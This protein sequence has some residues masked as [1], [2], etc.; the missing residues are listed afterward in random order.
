MLRTPIFMPSP[1]QPASTWRSMALAALSLLYVVISTT[2][3]FCRRLL[4][5]VPI[6]LFWTLTA[7]SALCLDKTLAL[8][9][10]ATTVDAATLPVV[11]MHLMAAGVGVALPFIALGM[12]GNRHCL[13]R[14]ASG[15]N[16]G[17]SGSSRTGTP[18]DQ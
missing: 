15:I 4:V 5:L 7:M 12:V 14:V 17:A 10:S 9:K 18:G 6:V 1:T 13:H 2:L 16:S 11:A 8:L 3:E